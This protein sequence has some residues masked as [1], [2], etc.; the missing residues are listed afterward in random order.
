MSIIEFNNVTKSYGDFTALKGA[1]LSVQ[2]GEI[3][4]FIGPNG[5]GKTTTIRILLGTLKADS[6][7]STMLGKD[8]WEHAVDIHKN[9]AYVPGDVSLWPNLTGGEVIDFF[10]KLKG[11]TNQKR[12]KELYKKFDLDPSKKIREYSK[13]NRQKVALISALASNAEVYI[14]DE[15]TTGLDPLMEMVFQDAVR[16]LKKEN[17]TVFLSSHILSEV[18]SLCDT[19]TIIRDGKIIETGTLEDLRYLTRIKITVETMK[20]MPELSK[21]EGISD[22]VIDGNKTVFQLDTSKYSDV[23]KYISQHDVIKLETSQPTLEDL[24]MQHYKK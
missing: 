4:G 5:A 1:T 3:H 14:F 21:Q 2:K 13:G 12:L 16:D 24:F 23:L 6:G 17:K 7:K 10:G 11:N 8:T 15:P 18:E 22:V 19:I 20:E 9:I